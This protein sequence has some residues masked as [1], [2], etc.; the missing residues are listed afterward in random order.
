MDIYRDYFSR[1]QL[2]LSLANVQF[3]PGQIGASGLFESLQL[4]GTTFAIE[5]N[6]DNDVAEMVGRPRGA[7]AMP[8]NLEK[9]SVESFTITQGYPM[10]GTILADEVLNIRTAGTSGAAEVLTQRRDELVAK[11]QRGMEWQHEYLRIACLNTPTNALGTAPAAAVV[12]FG[13]NDSA[14][15][16]AIHNNVVLPMESALGGIPYSGLDAWC[17]NDYWVAFIESKTVKE[18][19]LNYQAAAELRGSPADMFDYGGITWRRV[20]AGGNIAITSGQAKIVP[21]G[22]PGLFKQAFAPN[23]TLSSVGQGALGQPYYI[24]SKTLDDDKGFQVTLDSYPMMICTRPTCVLTVD[25][26]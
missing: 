8:L 14:L 11:L 15:R 12:A 7:P 13:S 26:S 16:T 3:Q 24:S 22:V 25:L 20:R 17:A 1:E 2:L 21:R 18:T 10:T 4:T 19:Y 9:R 23:D 5:V 6:P